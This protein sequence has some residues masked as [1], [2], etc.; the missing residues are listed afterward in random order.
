MLAVLAIAQF[1]LLMLLHPLLTR[2]MRRRPVQV[3][4][5]AVG[6]RL[7][8]VYLWHL[9]ILALIVVA[10]VLGRFERPVPS[11]RWFGFRVSDWSIG[12]STS[13]LIIPPFTVMV[14]GLN[15]TVA[16]TG[17]LLLIVAVLLQRPTGNTIQT[18][19]PADSRGDQK[20][21]EW[22]P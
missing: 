12:I 13:L 8:T 17:T 11:Y 6:S 14:F 1:S 18:R 9:P 20:A 10:R 2:A 15:L 21:S 5:S 7:M 22:R 19:L 4:V 3:I 16:I